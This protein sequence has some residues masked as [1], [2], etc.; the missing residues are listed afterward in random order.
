MHPELSR[1]VMIEMSKNYEKIE[2]SSG[3][4]EIRPLSEFERDEVSRALLLERITDILLS[5]VFGYLAACIIMRK[6]AARELE[7]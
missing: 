3:S 4:S 2:L 1:D 7:T 5:I 6:K